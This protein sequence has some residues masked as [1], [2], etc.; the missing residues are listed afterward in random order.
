MRLAN[1]RDLGLLIVHRPST[2]YPEPPYLS[3]RA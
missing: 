2:C 3:P 1:V